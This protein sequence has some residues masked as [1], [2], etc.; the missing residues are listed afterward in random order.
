MVNTSFF[1]LGIAFLAQTALCLDFAGDI[2][3]GGGIGGPAT[4]PDGVIH[5]DTLVVD[6]CDPNDLNSCGDGKCCV[7]EGMMYIPEAPGPKPA[8]RLSCRPMAME[9]HF[10]MATKTTEMCPCVTGLTCK[11]TLGSF[12]HCHQ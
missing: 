12:G 4:H 5:G 3:F 6:N 11:T 10:C 2:G 1:V 9:G 7:K 8:Y